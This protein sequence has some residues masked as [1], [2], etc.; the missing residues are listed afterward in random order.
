MAPGG[1]AKTTTY[2]VAGCHG[3]TSG[4]GRIEAFI[5]G[6]PHTNTIVITAEIES[7][8]VAKYDLF[9]FRCSPCFLVRGTTANGG[10]EG[11]CNGRHDPKCPSARRLLMVREDTWTPDEG[12]TCSWIVADEA[13]GCTR[14]F[15]TMWPS[16]RRLLSRV[17]PELGL[18]VNDIS[19]IHWSQHPLTTKSEQPNWR[20][21]HHADDSLPLKLRQLPILSS[22]TA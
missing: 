16:S 21:T 2:V 19:R 15:L 12:A 4:K 14:A 6:S 10:V 9:P 13:V 11:T 20:G 17:R 7:R 1:V 5:T 22:K 8:F 18:R 3:H